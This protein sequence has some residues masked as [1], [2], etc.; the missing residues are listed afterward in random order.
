MTQQ[1][2]A[3][4][5]EE[6]SAASAAI[7]SASCRRARFRPSLGT[8][9]SGADA[10]RRRVQSGQAG[11]HDVRSAERTRRRVVRELRRLDRSHREGRAAARQA[12]AAAGRRAQHRRHAARLDEREAVPARSDLERSTA[13]R[14][15]TP[16]GRSSDRPS[17]ARTSCRFSI[18]SKNTATTFKAPVRDP[19]M[20]LS[21]GPGHAAALKPLQ[22][23]PYWG[24]EAIWD[25]RVNNHNSMFDRDGRVWLAAAVRG[26]GQP[27]VL[28]ARA[29]RIRRRS[30]SRS[31][32]RSGTSRCSIRRRRSTRFVD[33]CFGTHHLQF[34]YDANDT[35]WTSGGG[36]VVGWL[37]TK[38]F[39][40]T[41]DAA[42]SQGWTAFV[43][44]TNGNGKRDDVRRARTSRSIRRRTSASTR[45]SMRSCRARSTDRSGAR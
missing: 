26:A 10:W 2:L 33:T 5:D 15:S 30:C 29:R 42:K 17:T 23:S 27:G 37:N 8:F 13:I 11:E 20:P 12:A 24:D 14:R 3:R 39:D 16:T 7:S 18:R 41:G 44:D 1:R 35:L 32:A 9:A 6:H 21:L 22:P 45:R 25:T 38:M 19:Q 4:R 34:G 40:E 43:L 36:P 28:Q 31:I